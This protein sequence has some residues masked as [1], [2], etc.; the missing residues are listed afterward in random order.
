M[1]APLNDGPA[2]ARAA[3]DALRRGDARAARDLFLQAAQAG[4]VDVAV[5]LGLA[6]AC[7]SLQ[8]WAGM[9]ASV[10]RVL[11][12]DPRNLRAL[13]MKGDSLEQAGDTKAASAYYLA[14]LRSAPPVDRLPPDL[15]QELR[16]AQQ[17]SDLFSRRY[18]DH[19][20][21]W[22]KARGFDESRASSRFGQA[23]DILVGRKRIHLQEPRYFYFPQLPQKQFYDRAD[24]PWLDAVEAA[25]DAIRAEWQAVGTGD[26]VYLWQNGELN[27]ANAALCPQT[28]AALAAAPLARIPGHSPSVLF[29]RMPQAGAHIPPHNGLINTRLIVH[30]PL[31]VPGK[32]RLRVGNE[33]RE[34]QE[35][36]AW[37]FDD[38]IDHEAWNDSDQTRVI[39]LFDIARPRAD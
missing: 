17:A 18:E 35:G 13:V 5:M 16:R 14:A 36:R 1:N 12:F 31:L 24:F 29:S 33:V 26:A 28:L 23:L 25:T 20:R 4:Q 34:W 10:D 19:M 30:L 38:S 32:C 39:L 2:L 22:L 9:G 7:R 8:D 15:L 27:E 21:A 37:V 11:A 6:Y 3:A